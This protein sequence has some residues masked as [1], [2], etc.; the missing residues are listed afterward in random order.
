[1]PKLS[2]T[3]AV[4]LAAAAARRDL[5]LLPVPDTIKL[6]GAALDR[7]I[8]SLRSRGFIHEEPT[9]PGSRR[10]QP[11]APCLVITL[12]GLA[13][14]GIEIPEAAPIQAEDAPASPTR[15]GGKLG[16]L[17]DALAMPRGATLDELAAASGWLPHTTRAALTRLRQRGFDVRLA[18]A[19]GRKAY[20]LVSAA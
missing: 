6:T 19:N 13:A 14:I 5:S 4:L 9:R 8:R 11:T 1:M 17:L 2:D 16:D 15:P 18:D 10:A 12:A 7:T 20:H 3:Q